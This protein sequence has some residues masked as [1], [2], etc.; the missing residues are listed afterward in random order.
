MGDLAQPLLGLDE[1]RFY[2]LSDRIDTIYHVGA[3][4][5]IIYP[6]IALRDANLRGTHEILRLASTIKIK[7]VHYIS[8]LGVFEASGYFGR[9]KPIQESESLLDC[10]VVYG[11]YCQSKWIA[12][13]TIEAAIA[14]GIPATIYRPGLIAGHSQTGASNSQDLFCR[15]IQY[16]TH[17]GCAP[18]LDTVMDVTPVD[19][20]SQAIV[21]LSRKEESLGEIF[22]LVNPQPLSWNEIFEKIN[23]IGYPIEL[24]EYSGWV[25]RVEAANSDFTEQVFGPMLPLLTD[26]MPDSDRRYLEMSS[27]VMPFGCDNTLRGLADSTIACPS[28]DSNLLKNYLAYYYKIGYLESGES[29]SMPSR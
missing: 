3:W 2:E 12:E 27:M 24:M 6:Y 7:P 25:K 22:H 28:V 10:G 15:L 1:E 9:K 4:V 16:F 13:K 8:T 5:N 23:A 17:L 11:G 19:Y 14:R 21:H 18:K 20:M 26:M 29:I